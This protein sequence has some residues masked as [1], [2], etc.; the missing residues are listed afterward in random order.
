MKKFFQKILSFVKKA[1]NALKDETKQYLPVAIKIVEALKKIMDSPVDDIILTV[2]GV[3]LPVLPID[4]VNIIKAKIEAELPKILIELNLVNSIA[5]IEDTNAQLQAILDALK[6]STDDTKAE[7]YHT[8]ASKLL[9]ILSDGK[10]SWGEAVMFTEW[11]YQSYIK[12][13]NDKIL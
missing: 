3:V 13:Q 12:Q 9:I 11:Y 8:L 2:V 10:V 7:K 4:K 6:V 5:N 1:F